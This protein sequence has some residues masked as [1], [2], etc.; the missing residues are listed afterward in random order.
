[1]KEAKEKIDAAKQQF[2]RGFSQKAAE[3]KLHG[4]A[5]EAVEGDETGEM[6]EEPEV[7]KKAAAKTRK[8]R[9]RSIKK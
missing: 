6:I 9:T 5:D 8:S 2:S 1:V 4:A 7:G 3:K